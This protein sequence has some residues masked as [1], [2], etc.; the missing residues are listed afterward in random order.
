MINGLFDVDFRLQKL[1]QNGDPLPQLNAIVPWEEFR[2]TLNILRDKP[3]KSTAGRKPFDVV[4]M[5]KILVLQSL[6]NISDDQ[7]EFQIADRLSF[8][9]FLN[10]AL[11]D[12]VPDAKTIWLFRD[13]LTK[14]D[15]A[16][17]LFGNFDSYLRDNGFAAK[18]GQIIDASIVSAPRQRNAR[19]ENKR[20]KEDE[21]IEGWDEPKRRQKDT[22]ARW[23][24]K[25]NVNYYGYKNHVS[26]DVKYKFIRDYEVTDAAVHDSQVFEQLLDP[27]KY[28]RRRLGRLGL[29]LSGKVYYYLKSL[30]TTSIYNAKV[31][32][33]SN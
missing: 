22:D 17:T 20:I 6:Y 9:R 32:E 23:T 27:K 13:D 18:K 11:D 24:K 2:P 15:L 21:E 7:L 31:R 3:R 4:L 25:N 12:R 16:K 26:T 28:Q 8:M 29:P 1:D 14:A 5:F 33:A 10:L 19:D 30:T